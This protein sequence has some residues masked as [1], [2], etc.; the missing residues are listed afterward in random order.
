MYCKPVS[1]A[2]D[3]TTTKSCRSHNCKT[4]RVLYNKLHK[5]LDRF[6]A[7]KFFDGKIYVKNFLL[8]L[9]QYTHLETT[10]LH[11]VSTY[12]SFSSAYNYCTNDCKCLKKT[13]M[14][15]HFA[16][17]LFADVCIVQV[18]IGK[19]FTYILPLKHLGAKSGPCMYSTANKSLKRFYIYHIVLVQSPL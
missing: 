4:T 7:T 3:S 9:V 10:I 17:L 19:F 18:I 2:G 5:R 11:D 15:K 14:S 8:L 12:R 6:F 13:Y 1:K 16:I